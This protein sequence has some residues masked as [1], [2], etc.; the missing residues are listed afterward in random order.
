MQISE[1]ARLV[2]AE[3]KSEVLQLELHGIDFIPISERHGQPKDLFTLWFGA[4]AMAITLA[5]G[6]IAATTGLGLL[7]GSLAIIVGALV[8]T[9]F[10]AYHSAQGPKLGLP[11]MIQSR[12]QFGF[13]GANIPM[14]I[15]I[16]MYLGFYAG[17]AILGAQALNLIF[18]MSIGAGVAIITALALILVSFGYNMMHLVGRIITPFYIVVFALLTVALLKNWNSFPTS[19]AVTATHLQLTPFLMVVSIIAAYYISYG[20]YVAD[21]SR[22]LPV[23][24]S[25]RRAFWYTY[26]GVIT[27]AVWIM[28]LGAGIQAAFGKDDAISGTAYV[29]NSMGAWLRLLTLVTLVLGLTNIGAFNIYGAMMS[30]LTIVSSVFKRLKVNRFKRMAFLGGLA[31][32]GGLIA[33]AASNDF[34]HAYENFICFI[35]TFLIPWSAINLVDYYWIRKGRYTVVDLFTPVGQYGGFNVAGLGAYVLG[36]LCQIPF[37]NQEF[38]TGRIAAHVGFD[39]AWV[40]GLIVPGA[41]YYLLTRK[42][43]GNVE[44]ITSIDEEVHG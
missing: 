30:S 25:I 23:E 13:Y 15:V 24:T 36:C 9:V 17:G 1:S 35:V 32:A 40:I 20:P 43:G 18:G 22:Y 27:S 21:Y 33:A 38:Y 26:A 2:S 6:A 42:K 12:A 11:Q 19:S 39:V 10:M 28:V 16:A 37:I 31:V 5:T 29:A 44:S 41:I 34:L 4:N 3:T 14:I 7:W 8:G